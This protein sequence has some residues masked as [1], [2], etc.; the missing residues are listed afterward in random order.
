MHFYRLLGIGFVI[1]LAGA[2][3][4]STL[5][6]SV[7]TAMTRTFTTAGTQ[8]QARIVAPKAKAPPAVRERLR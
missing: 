4:A 7:A 5:A 8:G 1:G 3:L 6:A 2:G